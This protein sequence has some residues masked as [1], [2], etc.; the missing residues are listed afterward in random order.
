M[1]K[2]LIL[3]LNGWPT[4]FDERVEAIAESVEELVVIRPKPPAEVDR[5]AQR[6]G[7]IVYDLLPSRGSF[8]EPGWIKPIVFPLHVVQAI[9]VMT[10]LWV[11]GSLPPVI[12]ALDYALGGIAGVVVSRLF[13]VPLVVSVRGLKEPRY[14]AIAEK[15]DSLRPSINYRILRA[16]TSFVLVN[17]D[18]VITKATYQVD[19]VKE[20]FG[21][22]PGFTTRPT[23]VDFELFDPETTDSGDKLTEL[24]GDS[25]LAGNSIALYLAKLLPEKGPDKV[26]ELIAAAD[27]ELPDDVMLA[28]VGEFR[29]EAFERQFREL[30]RD[31]SERV[32][33]H[34]KRVPFEDVPDLLAA[35]NAV[36]L[37][38][39][40]ESEGVPRI[41]QESCAMQTPIVASDVT[42]IAGAFKD[43]PGCYLVDREDSTAF[44]DAVTSAVTDTSDMPRDR[45]AERFD[46]YSN[47]AA[48]AGI[49]ETLANPTTE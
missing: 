34:S 20:T 32:V 35:A 43:L 5:L 16:M 8:V 24:F 41:L 14:K 18:H 11:R 26:L 47:Y 19:F 30:Q 9:L 45:F 42:G 12:H 21:V 48:Y 4:T 28:F 39:E 6:K 3:K 38:S 13:S 27:D 37:L 36:V 40:P 22:N 44:A 1:V 15:S 25:A 23:G 33:L 29:N 49:Y 7:V 17:T 31:V 46:M 2:A 10:Y